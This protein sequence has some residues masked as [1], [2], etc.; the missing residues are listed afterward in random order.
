M[1]IKSSWGVKALSGEMY[2]KSEVTK[3]SWEKLQI[4][5]QN[6]VLTTINICGQDLKLTN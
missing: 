4:K 3:E 5:V 6:F 2:I 1:V